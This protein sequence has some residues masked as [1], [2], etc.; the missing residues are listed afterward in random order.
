M[1]AER[2]HKT[3]SVVGSVFPSVYCMAHLA[4]LLERGWEIFTEQGPEALASRSATYLRYLI[5]SEY[6]GRATKRNSPITYH[7]VALPLDM[8]V[9]DNR[10]RHAFATGSYEAA[11]VELI[12]EY[13]EGPYDLMDLGAS[14]GFS[15][16]YALKGL[17]EGA[18]GVAVEANPEMIPV[19]DAVRELNGVDFDV[20]HAAYQPGKEEVTFHVHGKTVSSSTKRPGEREITVQAVGLKDVLKEYELDK[21]V[22]LA[23]IEGGEIDLVRDE[24][25]VLE[26]HCRLIVVELHEMDGV[27]AEAKQRFGDSAFQ[28]VENI[29]DV[30]VYH[31][32][33]L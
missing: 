10:V 16:V 15:T 30:Y 14:T 7:G 29:G 24:L 3:F 8:P 22:C 13:V 5:E 23:D 19:I 18:R 6:H 2:T 11:E 20:E 17:D 31:N 21:F 26:E 25:D 4:R 27:A 32:D 1:F 9:F 12:D 33:T 28:L